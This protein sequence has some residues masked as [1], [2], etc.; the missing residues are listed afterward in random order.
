L[1]AQQKPHLL[2]IG[3]SDSRVP[4][5]QIVALAPGEVFVH[6]NIANVIT[7]T[8]LNAHSVIQYA[9]EVLKVTSIIVTGH[10]GCGGVIAAMQ[11]ESVSRGLIDGW[12]MNVK[13]VYEANSD[14]L[15][16]IEDE[17]KRTDLLCE[18]NVVQSV[19]NIAKSSTVQKAWARGQSLS[20]HGWCYRL[21]D[22]L[23]RDLD[24]CVSGPEGI[25]K[26]FQIMDQKKEPEK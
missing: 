23:I 17:K 12:L 3:C 7:H 26:V 14:V 19:L 6:R 15:E 8:D 18:L 25:G 21:T 22:G 13:D 24:V 20:I 10:Y 9:V 1:A 2:W 11:K 16:A 5:N 4:A